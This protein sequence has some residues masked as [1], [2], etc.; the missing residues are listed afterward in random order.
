MKFLVCADFHHRGRKPVVMSTLEP[1]QTHGDEVPGHCLLSPV[2]TKTG[3]DEHSIV[4]D[5]KSV[6]VVYLS[7]SFICWIPGVSNSN[8]FLLSAKVYD[9]V[10]SYSNISSLL[11]S[12][13]GYMNQEACYILFKYI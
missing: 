8:E 11:V 9:A 7:C 1:A 6:V 12:S 10:H 5:D 4:G 2:W 13:N 3:G